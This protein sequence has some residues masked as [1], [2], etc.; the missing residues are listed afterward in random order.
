MAKKINIEQIK[1]DAKASIKEEQPWLL[2]YADMMTLLFAFFVLLYSMSSP[3]P[4]KMAQ[5]KEGLAEEA[6]ISNEYTIQSQSEI[7]ENLEEIIDKLEEEES[8]KITR[9]TR[10]VALEVS[11]TLGFNVNMA[12]LSEELKIILNEVKDQILNNDEDFRAVLIEGHSDSDPYKP[13]EQQDYFGVAEPTNWDLST[14]RASQVVKYLIDIGVNPGKLR[15]SGYADTWPYG[16]TWHDVVSGKVDR[17]YILARNSDEIFV[18]SNNNGTWDEDE[19][20]T[21]LNKNGKYDTAAD[22]KENNRRI[23]IVFTNQ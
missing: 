1:E 20:Y 13:K 4:V 11:G 16:T 21:D 2:T 5:L 7:E 22:N 17:E 15:P 3:D 14:A 12:E 10:G 23:K 18:D 9:D 19:E 8:T 6:G